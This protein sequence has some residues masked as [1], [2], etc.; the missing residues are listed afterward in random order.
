MTKLDTVGKIKRKEVH[1]AGLTQIEK[2]IEKI[3]REYCQFEFLDAFTS[4][5]FECFSC[6]VCVFPI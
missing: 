5:Q 2:D 4:H 1:E 3:K 6:C